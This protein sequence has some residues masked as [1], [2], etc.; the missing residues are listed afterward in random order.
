VKIDDDRPCG[1]P[2]CSAIASSKSSYSASRR[3][4]ARRSRAHGSVWPGIST[5]AGRR[6]GAAAPRSATRARRRHHAAGGARA[7]I[8]RRLHPVER[9]RV[10]QRADQR[11]VGSRGSPTGSER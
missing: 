6:R 11:A 4:S 9:R 5:S 1:T 3:G 8:E 7:S 2:L 10:D